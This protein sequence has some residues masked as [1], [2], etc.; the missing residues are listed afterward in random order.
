MLATRRKNIL[1]R[2][3]SLP[4]S[5]RTVP[6]SA[7]DRSERAEGDTRRKLDAITAHMSVYDGRDTTACIQTRTQTCAVSVSSQLARRPDRHGTGRIERLWRLGPLWRVLECSQG[8]C[9]SCRRN[10][11]PHPPRS[12]RERAEYGGVAHTPHLLSR[13]R[14]PKLHCLT[15]LAPTWRSRTEFRHSTVWKMPL[16]EVGCSDRSRTGGILRNE[17]C[18]ERQK[19]CST[20][21]W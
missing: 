16:S 15:S 13:R 10:R 9:K 6:S 4:L 20:C 18:G 21:L 17:P 3:S 2:P 19:S 12:E 8:F 14:R 7:S 1:K 5:R 11:K